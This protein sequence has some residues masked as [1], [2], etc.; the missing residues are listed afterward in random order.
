M[1]YSIIRSTA[2]I[3]TVA[4]LSTVLFVT[5][6]LSIPTDRSATAYAATSTAAPSKIQIMVN[7]DNITQD[8]KTSPVM[9]QGSVYLPL[10]EI[11]QRLGIHTYWNASQHT[12][13]LTYPKYVTELNQNKGTVKVNTKIM[14]LPQAIRT[15][16]GTTYVPAR[17]IAE[18]SGQQVSWNSKKKLITFKSN[19]TY[20]KANSK[21]ATIWFNTQNNELYFSSSAFAKPVLAG[22]LQSKLEN[23]A[24]LR[25]YDL[26]TGGH[27]IEWLDNFG[28][29][30]INYDFYTAFVKNDKIVQQAKVHYWQRYDQNVL[31]YKGNAVFVNGDSLEFLDAT[32]KVTSTRNLA[33]LTGVQGDY[34]VLGIGEN[35]LIVRPNKTGFLTLID[36][37]DK[38]SVLLYTTLLNKEE[39]DYYAVNDT[40][41]HGDDL[42]FTGENASG[43]LTFENAGYSTSGV[44]KYVYEVKD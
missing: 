24:T 9:I 10:R 17:V 11:S 2:K 12:I 22:K 7:T 19:I 27:V 35:Y 16:K 23:L 21:T 38:S 18:A 29:P 30:M 8:L 32:G 3:V 39:Q 6:L 4:L 42:V 25:L 1:V 37:R 31:Q 43:A 44:K 41:Y 20:V 13:I 40:P 36:L 33:T 26:S 14:N 34:S 28:E 5:S 15:I